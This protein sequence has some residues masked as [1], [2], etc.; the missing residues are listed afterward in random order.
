MAKAKKTT[1]PVK[2]GDLSPRQ[3][4]R[5]RELGRPGKGYRPWKLAERYGVS[6][7]RIVEIIGVKNAE[8]RTGPKWV[9]KPKAAKK[10]TPSK[11]KEVKEAVKAVRAAGKKLRTGEK[12][13]QHPV[14]KK[15]E[16]EEQKAPEAPATS[17]VLD[18]VFGK[19]T[20]D[21]EID[22]NAAQAA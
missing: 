16:Q 12:K 3:I 18:K 15:K 5:I 6:E 2:A 17:G 4:A 13:S 10:V 14:E 11:K 20:P 21:V 1:S 9:A 7:S 22:V 8:G 19:K